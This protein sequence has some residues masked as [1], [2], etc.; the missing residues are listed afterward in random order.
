[1]IGK[2]ERAENV[3]VKQKT[4]TFI[5]VKKEN[6]FMISIKSINNA[7]FLEF[8]QS[9]PIPPWKNT[10][11]RKFVAAWGASIFPGFLLKS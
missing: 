7:K 5:K 11:S 4:H 8:F 6:L 3:S 9:F 10:V 2:K 1:M